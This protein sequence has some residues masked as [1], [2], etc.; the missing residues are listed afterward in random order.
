MQSAVIKKSNHQMYCI[1]R[2]FQVNKTQ[3]SNWSLD[4]L[5]QL[6]QDQ[7][8]AYAS[9]MHSI[10]SFQVE[11]SAAGGLAIVFKHIQLDMQYKMYAEG[12]LKMLVEE[13]PSL[14]LTSK[15]SHNES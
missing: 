5:K 3:S 2:N 6:L 9:S 10:F 14:D 1:N 12:V 11:V 7:S 13:N 8:N 15:I 4:H